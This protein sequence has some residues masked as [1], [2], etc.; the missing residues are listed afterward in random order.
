MREDES[1]FRYV[2]E[3]LLWDVFLHSG[4]FLLYRN[5][6]L[7][8]LYDK[9]L[10]QDAQFCALQGGDNFHTCSRTAI[11]VSPEYFDSGLFLCARPHRENCCWR[12]MRAARS[13]VENDTLLL[14][15]AGTQQEIVGD[16]LFCIQM[17]N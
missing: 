16:T 1:D 10:R 7:C 3:I 11:G 9:S 15:C 5:L 8:L 2:N 6:K 17:E 4:A 14:D 13:V 12:N